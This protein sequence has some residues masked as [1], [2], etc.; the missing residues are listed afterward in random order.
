MTI[1]EAC[2][3]LHQLCHAAGNL[4]V[5]PTSGLYFFLEDGEYCGHQSTSWLR[6]TRCGSHK[7]PSRLKARAKE[8]FTQ[9][10]NGSAV[11]KHIGSAIVRRNPKRNLCVPWGGTDSR[12]CHLCHQLCDETHSYLREHIKEVIFAFPE[13]WTSAE[14]I[15]IGILAHCQACKRSS[16]WL[17][18]YA[19]NQ[20]IARGRLWNDRGVDLMPTKEEIDWFFQKVSTIGT[21]SRP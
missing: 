1:M 11:V 12:H 9:N 21:Y 6:I 4:V 14:N 7:T 18:Q 10:S 15:A 13:N 17:G 16:Q 8:H 19:L 20:V 3:K 2:E 5:W